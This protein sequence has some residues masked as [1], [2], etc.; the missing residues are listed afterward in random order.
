MTDSLV[1]G[2]KPTRADPPSVRKSPSALWLVTGHGERTRAAPRG[3][4]TKWSGGDELFRLWLVAFILGAPVPGLRVAWRCKASLSGYKWVSPAIHE[5]VYQSRRARQQS[6]VTAGNSDVVRTGWSGKVRGR[7]KQ[8]EIRTLCGGGNGGLY[9]AF[10]DI[11]I[12]R[13]RPTHGRLR[14]GARST[15][16]SRG[17]GE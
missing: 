2:E 7:Y 15:E 16:T 8:C 9:R 12:S 6:T 14:S 17:R 10:T 13:L 11:S 3:V 1:S 4:V 5:R